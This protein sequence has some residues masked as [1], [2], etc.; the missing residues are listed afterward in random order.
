MGAE[1]SQPKDMVCVKC[2]IHLSIGKVKLS[3]M[4]SD[5][6]VELFKCPQ[7]GLVYI[8]EDLARGKMQQVEAALEDK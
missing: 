5:F 1:T 3:Y 2:G 6:P 8:P 7:C 4:G